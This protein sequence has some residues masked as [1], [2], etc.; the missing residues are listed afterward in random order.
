MSISAGAVTLDILPNLAR[1]SEQVRQGVLSATNAAKGTVEV[2]ADTNK[3][4][5]EIKSGISRAVADASGSKVAV[6]AN[7]GTAVAEIKSGISSAV[8]EA[9]GKKVAVS[10]DTSAAS[11]K[12]KVDT[13]SAVTAASSETVKPKADGNP[14][15]T[16]FVSGFKS[17][18]GGIA[19]AVAGVVSTGAVVSFGKDAVSSFNSA[20]QSAMS[21]SRQ[22]GVSTEDASRMAFAAKESG[23]STDSFAS[24]MKLLEKGLGNTTSTS[25]TAQKAMDGLGISYKDSSGKVESMSQL[26]PSIA[27]K[28]KDMPDGANKTALAMQLFGKSGL[29]MLPML[30]KGSAGIEELMQKS[31]AY[32]NTISGSGVDAYKKSLAAQKDWSAALDGLKT[33]VGAQILPIMTSAVTMIT[34]KVIPAIVNGTKFFSEHKTAIENAGKAA[35]PAIAA[36]TGFIVVVKTINSISSAAKDLKAGL[37][38]AKAGVQGLSAGFKALGAAGPIGIIITAIAA[39]VAIFIELYTHNAKFR[40]FVNGI[41]SDAKNIIGSIVGWITG[42]LVP[43]VKAGINIAIGAFKAI[44]TGISDALHGA[45]SVASAIGGWFSG[46]FAGFFKAAFND[47]ATVATWLWH[48]IFQPVFQGIKDA[49]AIAITPIIIEVTLLKL[50]FQN[51]IAPV[52]MWLWHNVFEPVFGGIK[53]AVEVV[54]GWF[55]ATVVADWKRSTT[56]IATA[57]TWL[58]DRISDAFNWIKNNIVQPVVEWFNTYVVG[59]I[60]AFVNLLVD[61]FNWYRDQIGNAWN[62]IKDHIVQPVIDWFNTV[63]VGSIKAFINLIVDDFNWYRDRIGDAWNWIKDHIV[64][65]VVTWFET[66]VISRIKAFIQNEITGFENMRDKIGDAWNWVRNNLVEP[67]VSWFETNVVDRLKSAGDNVVSGFNSMK[68]AIG[69]AWK[70]IQDLAATPVRFVV[71]TIMAGVVNTYNDVASKFGADK[72][73]VPHVDF[74]TGGVLPG[75]TPGDDV[76]SFIHPL[77]GMQLNL[78]GG[79]A[80]MRP[81]FTAAVGPDWVQ[82]MNAL[83]VKRGSGGVKQA[84]GFSSGGVLSFAG[85]GILGSVEGAVSSALSK[86]GSLATDVAQTVVAFIKDPA[87][88]LH[89][90][91][92]GL[93][94]GIGSNPFAQMLAKIP[95]NMIDSITSWVKKTFGSIASAMSG[96]SVAS[97]QAAAAWA[98]Q[99]K[100][101]L[102]LAGLPTSDDYVQAWIRQI[103]TESGGNPNA[104]QGAIGDINNVT[105]NLARGLVQVIP[106]TFESF[107]SQALPDNEFAPVANLVAGMNYAKATYPDMLSFIG[108]GHGYAGGTENARSGLAWVGENGPELVNFRGGEQVFNQPQLSS[109]SVRVTMPN[110]LVVVDSDGVLLGTMRTKAEDVVAEFGAAVGARI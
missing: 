19:T 86:I 59:A 47:V 20:A 75:Y 104:V 57:F 109:S 82:Q 32:G 45:E 1:L 29:S 30:N 84:L 48:T 6:G 78:S 94:G 15:G 74:A 66:E 21:L 80:I 14:A 67:V 34:S 52:A 108:Q 27:E 36:I 23:V 71:N 76:Y 49:V 28:F 55:V 38:A 99:V 41:V 18:L 77:S 10:A 95:S 96:S 17:H 8:S 33:T 102:A 26:L 65:P 64:N 9:G 83:A 61:D 87:S 4:V 92:D 91:I 5:S 46:P 53:T 54:V 51:V 58:H 90:A 88:V 79:E 68:D 69:E 72:A 62:W 107:R 2:G 89:K 25:S 103:Q 81:E 22:L 42:T 24:S 100:Q 106:P 63:V 110:Q 60:K 50:L 40:A 101:A 39:L 97:S 56:D 12:I 35:L 98:P 11:D 105:G 3:A 93:L 7:T 70:K 43:G 31:D 13:K 37:G 73:N 85:G 16:S 44:G